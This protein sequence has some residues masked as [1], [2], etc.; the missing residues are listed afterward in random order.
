M[1]LGQFS[2]NL[3]CSHF[4]AAKH[5]LRYLAGTCSLSLLY[6]A[7]PS[8]SPSQLKGFM[9]N[10]GCSDADWASDTKDRRS[11][12]GFCFFFQ[13]SLIS[14]SAVKQRAIALS[15]TEAEYYALTHAFKKALWLRVFLILL[16]LPIPHLFPLFSDNQAAISLSSSLSISSRSKHIDIH[17]HFLRSHISDGSFSITWILL[18]TCQQTF[19][20][21]HCLILFFLATVPFLILYLY[22]QSLSLFVLSHS[23]SC[24]GV[25]DLVS[26]AG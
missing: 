15:S 22:L 1:W 9:H 14:W 5:V 10:L 26:S 8:V 2:S 4:L 23:S 20:L 21:N 3:L 7:S 25:L 6:G 11:I 17:H 12:S 18:Q 16:S 24:G 13:F 19:S